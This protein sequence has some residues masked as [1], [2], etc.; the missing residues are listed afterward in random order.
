VFIVDNYDNA[1]Q[2]SNASFEVLFIDTN[3]N[4]KPINENII[5]VYTWNEVY[6]T[7]NKLLLQSK[8]M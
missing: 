1:I 3:Y 2:F 8:A 6:L 5:R 4:I 7:I